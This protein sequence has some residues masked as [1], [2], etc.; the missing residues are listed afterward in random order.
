MD[1]I[2]QLTQVRKIRGILSEDDELKATFELMIVL[3]N[4]LFKN[5]SD[6]LLQIIN[7][8]LKTEMCN[9]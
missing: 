1:D 6:E 7:D 4:I 3:C 8:E 9:E 2:T 5:A